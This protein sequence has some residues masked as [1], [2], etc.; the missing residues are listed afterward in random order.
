MRVNCLQRCPR[1]CSACALNRRVACAE[2]PGEKG[3]DG[4]YVEKPLFDS[5]TPMNTTISVGLAFVNGAVQELTRTGLINDFANY[6]AGDLDEDEAAQLPPSLPWEWDRVGHDTSVGLGK[7][8]VGQ[9]LTR[10]I[11]RSA[12]P[13][14]TP[15]AYAELLKHPHKAARKVYDTAKGSSSAL[16]ASSEAAWAVS[17]SLTFFGVRALTMWAAD[18]FV[19]AVA[20]YR[21]QMSFATF[22]TNTRLKAVKCAAAPPP[23]RS[24]FP[25]QPCRPPL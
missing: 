3:G 12:K 14:L 18:V 25:H 2:R 6:I 7:D 21:Q 22:K 24:W 10:A 20:V 5:F 8:V 1:P 17:S 13:R 9:T 11:E 16:K 19:D 4:V 23:P 15:A